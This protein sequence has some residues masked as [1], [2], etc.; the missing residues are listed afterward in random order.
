PNSALYKA[1]DNGSVLVNT[2]KIESNDN[3]IVSFGAPVPAGAPVT[4]LDF[5]SA[6]TVA[7]REKYVT[8]GGMPLTL[9]LKAG[10]TVYKSD[11][12][13][14]DTGKLDASGFPTIYSDVLITL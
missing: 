14:P 3:A 13:F 10:G 9:T 4:R 5:L 8:T 11:L 1:I 12:P 6:A 2:I 7:L